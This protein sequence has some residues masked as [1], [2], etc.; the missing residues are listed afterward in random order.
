MSTAI[1]DLGTR[2]APRP[3]SD[4]PG[5]SGSGTAFAA[6]VDSAVNE[7][8]QAE[9]RTGSRS[10]T[11]PADEN[12]RTEDRGRADDSS[13]TRESDGKPRSR[14]EDDR[15][16]TRDTDRNATA[17]SPAAHA[18]HSPRSRRSSGEHHLHRVQGS[19]G[20]GAQRAHRH[21]HLTT[22]G[23][24]ADVTKPGDAAAKSA[25]S[26]KS[27]AAADAA[28]AAAA[29][30]DTGAKT[31]DAATLVGT[32][33]AKA[34]TIHATQAGAADGANPDV[35]G[36]AD[37]AKKNAA[38]EA[39]ARATRDAAAEVARDIEPA[40]RLAAHRQDLSA[41]SDAVGKAGSTEPGSSQ[42]ATQ[43]TS[44]AAANSGAPAVSAPSATTPAPAPTA[45]AAVTGTA[46]PVPASIAQP[47]VASILAQL[48]GASDGTYQL[49]AQVHPAELGAVSIT[50]TVRGG[51]L[52]VMLSAD[53]A[54]HQTLSQSLPQ[55]RDY[56]ADQGFTGVDVGLGSPDHSGSD[57]DG[58]DAPHSHGSDQTHSV[59]STE[60]SP[61]IPASRRTTGSG[62]TLD[63]ML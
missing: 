61:D 59:A 47:D 39:A 25:R 28:K 34:S 24:A 15:K 20:E 53:Q 45:A 6:A 1:I 60:V 19:A 29:L 7:Y 36:A 5:S 43:A 63:R 57:P 23:L 55:L 51:A 3:A 49:R 46:A 22:A 62:S 41:H 54:A 2:V 50:A 27:A 12:R 44:Q 35:A 4:Q 18:A 10:E 13:R 56:L 16:K 40:S 32:D 26:D 38:T 48:R 30:T 14:D 17:H 37:A 21:T 52:T 58:Q 31:S 42:P 9:Q 11:R 33:A 8:R